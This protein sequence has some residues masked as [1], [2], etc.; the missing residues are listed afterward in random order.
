MTWLIKIKFIKYVHTISG[1]TKLQGNKTYFC[2]D[3]IGYIL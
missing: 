1:G 2:S 3:F